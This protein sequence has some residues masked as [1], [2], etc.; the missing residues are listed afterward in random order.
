MA[1]SSSPDSFDYIIVGGGTAG[2]VLA[3]RLTEDPKVQV[4]VLEAG[5]D[6]GADP[7]VNVPAMWVELAGSSADWCFKTTP[8]HGLG[9]HQMGIAQGR[10]LGGSSALNSMNFVVSAKSNIGQ[11]AELGNTGW[12]WAT[13]SASLQKVYTLHGQSGTSVDESASRSVQVP[14]PDEDSKWP[15]VW[16]ETIAELGFPAHNHPLSGTISGATRSYACTAYL[17]PA[18][19]RPNLTVWTS[20]LVEKILFNPSTEDGGDPIAA[21]VQYARTKDDEVA[22]VQKVVGDAARL[23]SVCIPVVVDNPFVGEN[24]QNHP[25]VPLSFETITGEGLQTIDGLNRQDPAALGAA[26]E[27]YG[28]QTG[29]LSKSNGNVMAH[30]PF[31]NIATEAGKRELEMILSS[32]F[33]TS[34][35]GATKT[36]PTYDEKLKSY[37]RSV[38]KFADESSAFY[39]TV[40]GW[41]SYTPDGSWEPIPPGNETY[42]SIPVLL[43]H[44]STDDDDQPSDLGLEI[45]PNYLAH[46]LDVE[47]LARHVQF[48]ESVMAATATPLAKSLNQSEGAKR[49]S[50]LPPGPRAFAGDEGLDLARKYVR[51]SAV[52]YGCRNLR[53]C[54]ASVIPLATRANTMATVYAIAER[55]AEIIKSGI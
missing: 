14:V 52:V 12:D 5:E 10:L 25:V 48:V 50:A 49:S 15:Q 16:R 45:N 1:A 26:M 22:S 28:R 37:V 53:V 23:E 44:P 13:L 40:P 7:R 55:A 24:L 6:L 51:E 43:A 2:L 47:I 4:L 17:N 20:V 34:D 41:A 11:W 19:S 21:G 29:L 54:D 38:L 31:P 8:Q 32:A 18:T 36:A 3:S 42:F 33:P 30:M 39:I 9:G 27:A 35:T 46:P